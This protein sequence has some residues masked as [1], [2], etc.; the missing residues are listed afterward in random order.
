METTN[1]K[2]ANYK[3]LIE[4]SAYS[5]ITFHNLPDFIQKEWRVK[6]SRI[7]HP[8]ELFNK[9]EIKHYLDNWSNKGTYTQAHTDEC[10]IVQEWDI[11][12][13]SVNDPNTSFDRDSEDFDR[14]IWQMLNNNLYYENFDEGKRW[15]EYKYLEFET[16]ELGDLNQE[17]KF[18]KQHIEALKKT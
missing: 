16:E 12:Y 7:P 14:A 8:E 11:T 9:D 18:N 2:K 1:Y 5:F 6:F 15:I 4:A 10:N 3:K 17:A 13:Y